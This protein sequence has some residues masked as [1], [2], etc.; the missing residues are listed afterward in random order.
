MQMYLLQ[1]QSESEEF[2]KSMSSES[3]AGTFE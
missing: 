1:I 3:A 2:L